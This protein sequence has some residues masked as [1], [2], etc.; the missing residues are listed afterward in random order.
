MHYSKEFVNKLG[1]NRS[2][3]KGQCQ[4]DWAIPRDSLL[5]KHKGMMG[6]SCSIV[7]DKFGLKSNDIDVGNWV[8]SGMNTQGNRQS[9]PILMV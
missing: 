8:I 6:S 4:W 3:D 1:A 9:D 2:Q 7:S 5:S